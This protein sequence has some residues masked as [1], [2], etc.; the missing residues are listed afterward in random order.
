[1]LV[2]VARCLR[3]LLSEI[4]FVGGQ[5]AEL[6]VTSSGATRARPTKDVD[7]IVAA[8]T[9]T[10][11]QKVGETLRELGLRNDTHEDAPICRWRTVHDY[12]IDVLPVDGGFLGFRGQWFGDVVREAVEFDLAEDLSILIPPAPLFISIKW[13]AF[14]DR[15]REDVL[16]SHDLEDIITVVAGRPELVEEVRHAPPELQ[17]WLAA[18]VIDFLDD[19][20]SQYAIQGALP[21]AVR[22]PGLLQQV[23]ER[24]ESIAAVG[25]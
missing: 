8:T 19:E 6:L 14:L 25:K 2:E 20:L 4:V 21:D 10:E 7:V 13:D 11:Y 24:F 17:E 18:R 22:L 1:M 23:Q 5:V 16:G 15:G 3:P 12:R 9:A